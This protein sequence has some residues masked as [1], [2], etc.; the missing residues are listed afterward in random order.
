MNINKQ[1]S[2]VI[3]FID[4][5]KNKHKDLPV[6]IVYLLLVTYN[7]KFDFPKG[8]KDKGETDF[9]C[10]FRESYEECNL[11]YF[12]FTESEYKSLNL[13]GNLTLF[14]KEIKDSSYINNVI[15]IKPTK[16]IKEHKYYT[17][18]NYKNAKENMLNFLL[19]YLDK[20]NIILNK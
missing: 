18:K 8:V 4:N 16:G 6:D 13:N 11:N 20:A 10:A 2:G 14:I 15:K 1:G 12:S 7:N 19:P 3:A 5:R 9:D 17:F